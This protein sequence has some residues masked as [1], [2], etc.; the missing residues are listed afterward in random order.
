MIHPR[1]LCRQHLLGEH[2]EIHK[3]RHNFVKGHSIKGR[4]QGNA[5]EPKKMKQRHDAL[6]EE[7]INRG[8]NHSSPFEQPDLSSYSEQDQNAT[9][10]VNESFA[11]L[12]NRCPDCRRRI[13]I[14][15]VKKIHER[16]K[17][18]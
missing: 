15:Q 7:M 2:N 1:Y 8:Y 5:V 3:H 4:I 16:I 9:V 11:L 14:N 6:A 18:E 12:I 17:N 10:N 13:I